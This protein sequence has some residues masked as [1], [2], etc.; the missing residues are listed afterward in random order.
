MI[1]DKNQLIE[2]CFNMY[3]K[4]NS[5]DDAINLI[6]ET[7]YYKHLKKS[8]YKKLKEM[9]D[10]KISNNEEKGK[11]INNTVIHERIDIDINDDFYVRQ[12]KTQ[13]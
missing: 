4:M 7:Y 5:I 1:D 3:I 2:N 12:K 13:Q 6:E 10:E 11:E 9:A 8:V